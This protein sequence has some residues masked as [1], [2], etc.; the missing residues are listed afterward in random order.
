LAKVY[1]FLKQHDPGQPFCGVVLFA[2]RSLEPAQ[3]APYLPLLEAG[4]V[5]R[6]YL[7]EMPELANAPLGL[8]ILYLIRRTEG[9]APSMARDLVTRANLE[10]TD[11]ALKADL[12]ELIETVIIYKLPRLSREEIQIMLQVHDIRETRVY[13][14]ALQEGERKK[15]ARAIVNMAA[16]NMPPE[17]IAAL[18][19]VGIEFVHQVLQ[20][21]NNG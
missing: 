1:T 16:K 20:S 8:S 14:E 13:Q 5:R 21:R 15:A 6:F 7:D 11:A 19:E 9:Q 3:T 18:L 4:L 17:E 2:S 10:I 12:I